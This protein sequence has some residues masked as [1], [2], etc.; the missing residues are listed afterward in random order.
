MEEIAFQ[1]CGNKGQ[2]FSL[3][4][5]RRPIVCRSVSAS[6]AAS[7]SAERQ[8]HKEGQIREPKACSLSPKKQ[9][10]THSSAVQQTKVSTRRFQQPQ[11]SQFGI[12]R[13]ARQQAKEMQVSLE[14]IHNFDAI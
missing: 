8:Q 6:N 13:T 9:L 3:L 1:F 11:L 7:V 2:I 10:R 12:R 14:I 4:R 5:G